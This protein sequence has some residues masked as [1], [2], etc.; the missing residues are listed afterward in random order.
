M[1]ARNTEPVL[2]SLRLTR[3]APVGRSHHDWFYRNDFAESAENDA[4]ELYFEPLRRHG[5]AFAKLEP[6]TVLPVYI[7]PPIPGRPAFNPSV[8][9]APEPEVVPVP[10]DDAGGYPTT[11]G[12]FGDG[13]GEEAVILGPDPITIAQ[14]QW[15]D[16]TNPG[17]W[18][19]PGGGWGW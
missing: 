8:G 16:L 14:D 5:L 15:D 1:C 17:G 2:P 11:G 13:G 7:E 10:T 3:D 19:N 18:V 12:G 6:V 9:A 4:I